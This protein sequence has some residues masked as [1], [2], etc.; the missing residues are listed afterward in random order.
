VGDVSWVVPTVGFGTA[1]WV[2]GTPGHSWQAVAC[3]G[4]TIG[5]KGMQLAAKTLAAT[6]PSVLAGWAGYVVL[7][8]GARPALSP[9]AFGYLVGPTG[10][11]VTLVLGP[12]VAL[13]GVGLAVL[14]SARV[15][16]P[17]AA[18]Q[19]GAVLVLPIVGLLFGQATG[20]IYLG[21]GVVV[22][23]S[24]GAVVA[25]LLLLALASRLFQRE[26]ILTR[27]T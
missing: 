9:A 1:C 16:D 20:A 24:L 6:L 26:T 19:I 4:T 22:L 25:N 17:R 21:P 23:I 18:Q 11:L 7:V 14:A 27:W 5:K 13:L 2:P 3:G 15:D 8:I 12:L 10:L